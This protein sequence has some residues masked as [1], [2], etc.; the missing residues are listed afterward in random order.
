MVT[1]AMA[2]IGIEARG[3]TWILVLAVVAWA[4]EEGF[5]YTLLIR[6]WKGRPRSRAKDQIMRDAVAR[7]PMTAHQVSATTI[8]TITVVPALDLTPS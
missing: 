3:S 5:V 7:N 4:E 1:R 6:A 8:E 2:M